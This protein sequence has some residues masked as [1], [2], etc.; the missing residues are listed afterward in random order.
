MGN[1][2]KITHSKS[3]KLE[4]FNYGSCDDSIEKTR[5]YLKKMLNKFKKI[6]DFTKTDDYKKYKL[7]PCQQLRRISKQMVYHAC[8]YIYDGIILELG[9]APKKCSRKLGNLLTV[10]ENTCGLS[11]LYQFKKNSKYIRIVR[12]P[13][14]ETDVVKRMKRALECVGHLDYHP[15]YNNCITRMNYITYGN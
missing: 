10:S 8:V 15:I 5:E 3:K 4:K 11:T 2:F 6:D 14:D 7:L 12:T 13:N 1:N 9:S